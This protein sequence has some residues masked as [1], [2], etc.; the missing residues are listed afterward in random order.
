MSQRLADD[1]GGE[2]NATRRFVLQ[3]LLV[4]LT[5]GCAT[6]EVVL[7]HTLRPALSGVPAD[8]PITLFRARVHKGVLEVWGRIRRSDTD[9]A[10]DFAI[11]TAGTARLCAAL[12]ESDLTFRTEWS[13]L[14]LE[15]TYE[16][17]NQWRWRNT[18]GYTKVRI[19]RDTL[20]ELRARRVPASDYP[21][22]WHLFAFKVGPPDYQ[23]LYQRY[24]AGG[25]GGRGPDCLPSGACA[26]D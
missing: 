12:A 21:R 17:G 24:C 1:E 20:L 16:Y 8:L 4:L 14:Q 25:A 15:F 26:G 2:V 11:E 9:Y 13:T 18:L 7:S 6:H 10:P 22:Y 3:A 5:G 19:G 23:Y